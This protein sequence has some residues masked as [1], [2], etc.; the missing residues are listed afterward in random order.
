MTALLPLKKFQIKNFVEYVEKRLFNYYYY[1]I[2]TKSFF[3]IQ[4][5]TLEIT[6]KGTTLKNNKG[7][8]QNK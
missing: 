6:L 1:S 4:N 2:I 5:L 3:L 7:F 8:S